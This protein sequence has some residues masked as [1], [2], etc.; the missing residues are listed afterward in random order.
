[1]YMLYNGKFA[2]KVCGAVAMSN[3][4]NELPYYNGCLEFNFSGSVCKIVVRLS[5]HHQDQARVS[6]YFNLSRKVSGEVNL[7]LVLKAGLRFWQIFVFQQISGQWD[8]S[9]LG[10]VVT[11]L[12]NVGS[13]RCEVLRNCR[14]TV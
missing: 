12:Q 13:Y 9:P 2:S 14:R 6:V 4:E 10:T 5:P 7:A 11:L 8:C 3:T 1:M